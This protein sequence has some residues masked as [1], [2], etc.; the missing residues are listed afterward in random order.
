MEDYDRLRPLSYPD[1][2]FV[3]PAHYF[4]W[5]QEGS[6]TE[7]DWRASKDVPTTCDSGRGPCHCWY[8]DALSWQTDHFIWRVSRSHGRSARY[9]TLNALPR[10]ARAS[11]RSLLQ[12][13]AYFSA[14]LFYFQVA[15]MS[16]NITTA[17]HNH[18]HHHRYKDNSKD[19]E[20]NDKHD[21]SGDDDNGKNHG[22]R[23]WWR[24]G[25][26][27]RGGWWRATT[28]MAERVT[29]TMTGTTT[30]NR[31]EDSEDKDKDWPRWLLPVPMTMPSLSTGLDH[32]YVVPCLPPGIYLTVCVKYPDLSPRQ[33][34]Y[35]CFTYKTTTLCNGSHTYSSPITLFHT[36][37]L[38]IP[39]KL[40]YYLI[41]LIYLSP[42]ISACVRCLR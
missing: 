32:H 41:Y 8:L 24:R 21:D 33:P 27:R 31:N 30:R 16:S 3:S 23:W 5:V 1:S 7:N 12:L 26:W 13:H 11:A 37:H 10:Q 40:P 35:V 25:G 17:H 19:N 6:Q 2:H 4:C 9:V 20:H 14:F 28:V 15:L 18:H 42:G 36:G 34:P 38:L 39:G 29:M 22:G